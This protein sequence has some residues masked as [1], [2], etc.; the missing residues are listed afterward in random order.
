M[1]ERPGRRSRRVLRLIELFAQ[2]LEH[3][4]RALERAAAGGRAA[5]RL[6]LLAHGRL[7]ARQVTGK[8]R[9]L[10]GHQPAQAKYRRECKRHHADHSDRAWDPDPLE[11]VH[12]GR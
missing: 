2:I 6:D 7:V 10:R 12:H 11:E 9:E 1:P 8:L 4:G 5:E 3:I